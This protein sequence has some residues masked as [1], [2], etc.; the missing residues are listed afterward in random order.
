MKKGSATIIVLLV[1]LIFLV[2]IM[3]VWQV[4]HYPIV[5]GEVVYKNGEAIS[6]SG[7]IISK[8]YELSDF[9]KIEILGK[10]NL[11]IKESEDYSVRIRAED[12]IIN[13]LEPRIEKDALIIGER[14]LLFYNKF[15]IDIYISVPEVE[16]ISLSGSGNIKGE[17]KI[18]ESELEIFVSGT[19]DID[20]DV[21]VDKLRT[22]ISGAGDAYYTGTAKEHRISIAGSGKVFGFDLNTEKTEVFIGG[23]GAVEVLANEKLDINIGGNGE[24]T[25]IGN[26]EITQKISGIGKI[27]P[28]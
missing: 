16:K 9:K 3:F 4:S 2:G 14:R 27:E 8:N 28:K 15:P 25:Y 24:V 13:L 26:P 17:N 18:T 5:T 22:S 20:L 19:S 7:K 23:S 6:G 12:N 11:F 1:I 10:G 21:D